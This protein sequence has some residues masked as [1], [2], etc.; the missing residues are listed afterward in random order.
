MFTLGPDESSDV[1]FGIQLQL[2]FVCRR[3]RTCYCELSG[4]KSLSS[5]HSLLIYGHLS[6]LLSDHTRKVGTHRQLRCV[7]W[8]SDTK[9]WHTVN[10]EHACCELI[11][12]KE[13]FLQGRRV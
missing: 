7:V 13:G 10:E 4:A 11:L 6:V 5:K 12:G 9:H 3:Q 8:M 2:G 1:F